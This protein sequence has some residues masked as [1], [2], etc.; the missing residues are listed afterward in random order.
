MA[1]HRKYIYNQ[2]DNSVSEVT[3]FNGIIYATSFSGLGP[4]IDKRFFAPCL[5]LS[6]LS[7]KN[8]DFSE[9]IRSTD[10]QLIPFGTSNIVVKALLRP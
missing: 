1:R 2:F 8:K 10:D 3:F 5:W 4:G 7:R 6:L 9:N